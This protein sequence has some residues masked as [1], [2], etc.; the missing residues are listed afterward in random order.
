MKGPLDD[1]P[2]DNKLKESYN[3]NQLS[4]KLTKKGFREDD[5]LP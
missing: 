4:L 3:K 5:I 2:K 1:S